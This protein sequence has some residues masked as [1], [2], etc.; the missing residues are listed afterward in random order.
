MPRQKIKRISSI[1]PFVMSLSAFIL[2]L[3]AVATGWDKGMK[4]EGSAAHASCRLTD[5]LHSRFFGYAGLEAVHAGCRHSEFARRRGCV[6][7]WTCRLFQTVT[8]PQNSN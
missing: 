2:V 7:L 4:D 3:V 6:G 5:T 1:A 8:E